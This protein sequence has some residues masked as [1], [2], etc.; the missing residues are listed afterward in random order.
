[1][2]RIMICASGVITSA[3]SSSR[4]IQRTAARIDARSK[5]IEGS[6]PLLHR[7]DLLDVARPLRK[8]LV[9][10]REHR[11][12]ERLDVEAVLLLD[13][14]HALGL[15]VLPVLGIRVAVPVDRL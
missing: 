10:L 7:A 11:L 1:M 8:V 14:H 4:L 15:E 6:R 13:E 5:P 2:P 9:H 12:A 3:A